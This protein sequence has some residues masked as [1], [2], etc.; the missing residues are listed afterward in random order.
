MATLQNLLWQ[1]MAELSLPISKTRGLAQLGEQLNAWRLTPS[2]TAEGYRTAEVTRGGVA[3][4]K[5]SSKPCKVS[6]KLNLYFIGEVLDVT[7]WLGGY[8]F[9]WAWAEWVR[10]WRSGLAINIK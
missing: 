8:N 2:G 9:Q 5:V 7:G 3:T 10:G 6:Y 4:D 1:D